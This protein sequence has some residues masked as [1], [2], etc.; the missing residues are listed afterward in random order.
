[1]IGTRYTPE[2]INDYVKRGFWHP[3]RL[4]SDLCQESARRYP[5]KEAVVDAQSR[6]TWRE[7]SHRID[8]IA[9]GLA[10]LGFRRD[11]VIAT[12]LNNSVDYFLLFFACEKA[13]IILATTQ[14]TFRH[15]EM[16]PILRQTRA[17]GI[18]INRSFRNFDYFA[19]V[20]ELQPKLPDLKHVIVLGDDIPA[21]AV[22]F[23]EIT[24]CG[25]EHKYPP[26]YFRQ[27]RF[28]PLEVTQIFN[29]SGTTGI[30]KCI[31]RPVAPRILSGT[32]LT[33]RLGVTSDDVIAACWNL[34]A[35]GTLFLAQL[36]T[37][38]SGAKLV[39][40][41]HFTPQETCKIVEREKVT[42]LAI[43]PAE[44]ARLL[45]YPDLDKYDLSSLKMIFTATQL[46]TPELGA[47]AEARLNCKIT[48]I[49]G[50]GDI[51][52]ISSTAVNDPPDVRLKT[53]GRVMDGNEVRVIDGNGKTVP[54]GEEGELC[55][56]GPNLVSGYYGNPEMTR[57]AWKDGWFHVG[58][59]ARLDKEGHIILLGRK[60]DVIKRGGQNIFP[61]EIEGMLMQHPQ[62][63]NVTIVRMPDP[64]M[65]EKQCAYVIPKP[66]QSLSFDEMS[67]F[68][69]SQKIA[70]YK[71]PERLEIVTDFPMVAAG[72]KV[73]R[74]RLE[75]DIAAKLKREQQSKS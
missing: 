23:T 64:V 50:A 13:G 6:L 34:A 58:D 40:V 24:N 46:L 65:G 29:T 51:S 21:G 33:K 67:G 14:P 45:D 48:M 30:P 70:P 27:V 63:S 69:R 12:Q 7:V 43:V 10:D 25:L 9:R 61:A 53:V 8:M 39:N 62:V 38:L 37:P 44:I 15:A 71:I 73:D 2:M 3:T 41:A 17:K 4:I 60:R 22:S 5:D 42:I 18:I 52:A 72:N 68:L 55:V 56:R 26:R 49:Y 54:V 47:R 36:C 59:A 11:D 31:E 28:N 35:G 66:G 19:M 16:E 57:E 74:N 20:Q 1:M 32:I 75:A